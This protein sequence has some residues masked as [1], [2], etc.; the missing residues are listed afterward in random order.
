MAIERNYKVGFDN[1]TPVT[2]TFDEKC[3]AYEIHTE[4]DAIYVKEDAT[5][6]AALTFPLNYRIPQ[7]VIAER[8]I[9]CRSITVLGVSGS[10]LVEIKTIPMAF[11]TISEEE[12]FNTR[13]PVR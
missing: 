11:N 13:A 1:V 5:S 10:G 6:I 3:S 8:A 9:A 4:D 7:N 2:I 12:V